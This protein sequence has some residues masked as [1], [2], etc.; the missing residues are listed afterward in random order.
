M[1]PVWIA[2]RLL[3]HTTGSALLERWLADV[4]VFYL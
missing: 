1:L 3:R 4:H 2:C